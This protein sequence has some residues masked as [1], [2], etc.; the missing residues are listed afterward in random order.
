MDTV[1]NVLAE[2]RQER[3]PWGTA[4]LL[5]FLLHVV[6]LVALL[7]SVFAKPMRYA[8]P[9]AVAVRLIRMGSPT[10]PEVRTAPAPVP[11]PPPAA[12]KP[13]IEKPPEEK[14]PQPSEKALLLPSK[15][16]ET[17]KK[18]TPA[19][20]SRPAREAPPAISL[21]N[22]GDES[23]GATAGPAAGAGGASAIGGL[24]LDQADFK[25]PVY[26]ER[27]AGILQQNWLPLQIAPVNPVVHFQIEKDGTITDIRLVT[28]SG[29]PWVDRAAQR[30]VM[31]SSPLPPLPSEYAGTRLG[32]QVAFAFE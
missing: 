20:I 10:A 25:Y 16:K 32:V 19:P 3:I 23:A 13:K 27:M 8:A 17:K 28:A 11:P 2:R 31:A 26:I 4:A 7:L 15:E 9:R 14:P 5:A 18:P 24:K 6:V 29:L 12:E 21:P 1:A 22:A 30:A